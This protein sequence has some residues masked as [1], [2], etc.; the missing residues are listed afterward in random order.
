MKTNTEFLVQ[1][2]SSL[3]MLSLFT[4]IPYWAAMLGMSY[5]EIIIISLDYGVTIFIVNFIIGRLSDKVGVR[6]PFIL[7]GLVITGGSILLFTFPQNFVEFSLTRILTAIG[8]GMYIP[9]LTA[10]VTD[11]KMKL[12]QFSGVGTAAWAGGVIISGFI[13]IFWFP[14]IWVFSGLVVLGSFF[15][16]LTIVEE[17]SDA[18]KYQFSSMKV[19]WQR[20]RIFLGFIV[21][22]SLA[23]AVWILWPVYLASI[24]ANEF[25]IALIQLLN[26]VTSSLVMNIFTDRL[27][28][29]L[30]FN[31]GLLFSSITFLGYLLTS[32]W[33]LILPVQVILGISWAFI[34]VGALRYAI[35][36]SDFDRSTVA[37][38]INSIQS[39]SVI[40]GSILAFIIIFFNG[41][42]ITLIILAFVGILCM[43]II[44]FSID[45]R[46]NSQRISSLDTKTL[47]NVIFKD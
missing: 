32:N 39:I 8:F 42:F 6:K 30:M 7:I 36:S 40:L 19:F 43:F 20:K 18:K 10:L 11:K 29:K 16:A 44:N 27:D 23:S 38:W 26:P 46:I 31:L 21:R 47:P 12:G 3:S 22:H 35:E 37:G 5:L 28:S 13:G 33:V 2:I 15:M 4:Y 25:A 34:Y 41:T 14:G 24:G 17:K 1:F 45:F 9:T